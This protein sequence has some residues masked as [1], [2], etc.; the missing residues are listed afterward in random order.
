MMSSRIRISSVSA[1]RTGSGSLN[2]EFVRLPTT[3]L[4]VQ[5]TSD[6]GTTIER[7]SGQVLQKS[8]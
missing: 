3:F 5:E 7:T 1:S 2:L 4:S 6:F 8:G